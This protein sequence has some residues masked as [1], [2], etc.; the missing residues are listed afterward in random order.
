M[1]ESGYSITPN[2]DIYEC[3]ESICNTK[4]AVSNISNFNDILLRKHKIFPCTYKDSFCKKCRFL[5]ICKGGCPKRY[6]ERKRHI[7]LFKSI[8]GNNFF[9]NKY[10]DIFDTSIKLYLYYMKKRE[11]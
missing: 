9:I 4:Y 11:V 10:K 5:P 7:C 2:G 6:F 3:H 8:D 1:L